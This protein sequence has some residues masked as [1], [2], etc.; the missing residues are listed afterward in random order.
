MTRF[1]VRR[2]L[3]AKLRETIMGL[4]FNDPPELD[5][6]AKNAPA[7]PLVA[8]VEELPLDA[9]LVPP[10]ALGMLAE[11]TWGPATRRILEHEPPPVGSAEERLR[12]IKPW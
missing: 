11:R 1:H 3:R 6:P 2:R 8:E 7:S 5:E 4:L 9:P 12:K 10:E